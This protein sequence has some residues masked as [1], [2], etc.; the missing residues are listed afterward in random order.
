[1]LLLTWRWRGAGLLRDSI[2]SLLA[3]VYFLTFIK[4]VQVLMGLSVI[5]S[6]RLD[7]VLFSV[8]DRVVQHEDAPILENQLTSRVFSEARLSALRVESQ[9]MLC[10]PTTSVCLR[11]RFD[12][13]DMF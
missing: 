5:L 2:L 8:M 4:L 9:P 12:A 11:G 7:V 1:M 3:V 6:M 13:S 10:L